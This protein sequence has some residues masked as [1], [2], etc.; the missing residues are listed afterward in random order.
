MVGSHAAAGTQLQHEDKKL[1]DI[2]LLS[3][4]EQMRAKYAQR[5]RKHGAREQE[6]RT[7]AMCVLYVCAS[8]CDAC[9]WCV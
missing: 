6:V 3:P 5:K 1:A 4:L 8:A 9:C 7:H 2:N